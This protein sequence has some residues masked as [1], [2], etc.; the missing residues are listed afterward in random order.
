MGDQGLV[1]LWFVIMGVIVFGCSAL[2]VWLYPNQETNF[3][4]NTTPEN[5]DDDDDDVD[6]LWE[7]TYHF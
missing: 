3:H 5:D 6:A 1:L 2:H 4:D 7:G